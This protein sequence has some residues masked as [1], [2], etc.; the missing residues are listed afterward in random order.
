MPSPGLPQPR[1]HHSAPSEFL[2]VPAVPAPPAFQWLGFMLAALFVGGILTRRGWA[3]RGIDFALSV[4]DV[5][6]IAKGLPSVLRKVM[7][8]VLTLRELMHS[9]VLGII[10]DR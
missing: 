9:S 5:P 4:G 3:C 8:I 1:T 7:V 2:R 10:L 6:S